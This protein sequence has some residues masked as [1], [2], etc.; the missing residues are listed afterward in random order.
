MAQ[1]KRARQPKQRPPVL[2]FSNWR[3]WRIPAGLVF[4]M[5]VAG[6]TAG[7]WTLGFADGRYLL[8]QAYQADRLWDQK[9]E[10]ERDRRSVGTAM[11][12]LQ[13]KQRYTPKS[14]SASDADQL[15]LLEDQVKQ[16]DKSI[17][18]VEQQRKLL[19]K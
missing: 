2:D 6:G 16:I 10:L 18:D 19:Q 5:I 13:S 15:R 8:S 12:R 1:K 3:R 7:W 14:F 9:R 4:S 17:S 11:S